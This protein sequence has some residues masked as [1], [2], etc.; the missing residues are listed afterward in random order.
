MTG[1]GRLSMTFV[2]CAAEDDADD[3][4]CERVAASN[5]RSRI[6]RR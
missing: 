6:S 4:D 2:V 5:K 1:E 3:A